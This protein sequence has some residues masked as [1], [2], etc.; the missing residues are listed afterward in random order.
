MR[1]RTVRIIRLDRWQPALMLFACA[2]SAFGQARSPRPSDASGAALLASRAAATDSALDEMVSRM[3]LAEKVGTVLMVPLTPGTVEPFLRDYHCGSFLAWGEVDGV[4]SLAEFCRLAN[5]AQQLSSKYRRLPVWLHGHTAGLGWSPD[6]ISKAAW[7]VGP[8][9]VERAAAIFGRRWRAVGL[10]NFPQPCLNVPL[11]STGIMPTWAISTDPGV[12][13]RYG[14][15]LTRGVLS[16]RC[17]TMA[18]HF[19]AHGATALD[20]HKA[21]PV[22]DLPRERLWRDHLACYQ[23]CFDAGCTS[24]CTAHLACLALDPDPAQIATTSHRILTDY[25]RGEM[26]FRGLVIADAVEMHGFQKNGPLEQVAIDAVN[27]GCDSLCILDPGNVKRVFD[28]LLPAAR[29]GKISSPRLDEAVRRNLA[30]MRWL[31]LFEKAEVS[32]EEA[33][34]LLAND[35]DNALLQKVAGGLPR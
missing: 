16:A 30:F 29:E 26:K 15:A 8:G 18:C 4:G 22:V 5:Q 32:A 19:P 24:I 12:V 3:S 31:G 25:L 17:G 21:Y 28:R 14:L 33:T 1:R 7:R 23:A 20:S 27:A 2:A 10:H 35:A 6:W 11:Y 13:A 34:K 9:D